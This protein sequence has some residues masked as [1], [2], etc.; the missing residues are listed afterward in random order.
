MYIY[1]YIHTYIR[2]ESTA[3]RATAH[4]D[5]KLDK[6]VHTYVYTCVCTIYMYIHTYIHT[7]IYTYVSSPQRLEPLHTSSPSSTNTLWDEISST[8]AGAAEYWQLL[9]YMAAGEGVRTVCMGGIRLGH[10][11]LHISKFNNQCI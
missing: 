1:I 3:T 8:S 11:I 5:F 10:A 7:Y 2:I 9:S 4:V 6:Y